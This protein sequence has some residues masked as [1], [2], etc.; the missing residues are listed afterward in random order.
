M[1]HVTSR[2]VHETLQVD[3]VDFSRQKVLLNN[4]VYKYVLSVLDVFS[5]HVWLRPL[6]NKSANTVSTV[7]KKF[8]EEYGVPRII[9]HDRGKE[10]EGAF[11]R[12]L[13]KNQIRCIK[14]RPYHPQSQGKFERIHRTLKGNNSV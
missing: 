10:F 4:K 7:L 11:N 9:Q 6:K 3:L 14:S 2:V 1:K 5:R 8:L 13:K 12:L